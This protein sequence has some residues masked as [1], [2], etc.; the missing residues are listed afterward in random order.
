MNKTHWYHIDWFTILIFLGLVGFGWVNIFA[1]EYDANYYE[2]ALDFSKSYGKQLMWVGVSLVLAAIALFVDA[3]F[4]ITFS[5][6][7]F[8]ATLLLLV[9]TLLI[10]EPVK[11]AT[12]W[13]RIGGFSLQPTEFAKTGVVLALAKFF[14]KKGASLEGFRSKA[15]VVGILLLP[16][17]L[18]ILQNDFGSAIVFMSLILM[19]YRE[20]LPWYF[21]VIP[22][23][24]GG[25]FISALLVNKFIIIGILGGIAL[26]SI[27]LVRSSTRF[28][29]L[30][31]LFGVA[32]SGFVLGSD[33]AFHNVLKQ[34]H[35]NR[36]LLQLGQIEDDDDI[37]YNV[38]QSL[39]AIG[40]GG[41]TGKGFLKGTH[42]TGDFVP[43][44]TTDFIFCTVGEEFGLAGTF[45]VIAAF[46]ILLLRLII[47]AERQ[48]SRFARVYGYGVVSIIF[49]H[50]FVNTAMTIGLFPA[51]GI[52]LP[53]FS[54]G[55]SSLMGFTVLIFVMLKLDSS[56][57]HDFS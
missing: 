19:L 5:N 6:Y 36:L 30:V 8:I 39:I 53:F 24:F 46:G 55:G 41:V 49:F 42:T 38:K 35:R 26:I 43:E 12:S 54:Y 15:Q 10:A 9:L 1:A 25:L 27:Y 33:Y 45:A 29:G 51:I 7:I 40:S 11:G 4:Y 23:W 22:I 16:I 47:L 3:R 14:D 18:I 20:G 21:L 34:H 44:Q 2:S 56:L 57:K 52:P 37:G 13:I 31:L 50:V 17:G 48:K 28:I 32:S